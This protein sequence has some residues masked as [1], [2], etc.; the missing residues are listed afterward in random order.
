[1]KYRV[2]SERVGIVGAEFIAPPG[3][4]IDALITGGFIEAVPEEAATEAHKPARNKPKK[5]EQE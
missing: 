4:N 3:T 2:L 5:A 1:M